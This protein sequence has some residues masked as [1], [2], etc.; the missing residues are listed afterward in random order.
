MSERLGVPKDGDSTSGPCANA[1]ERLISTTGA[2]FDSG[3]VQ[4]VILRLR[5][6]G[7]IG[8][9][10]SNPKIVKI[11]ESLDESANPAHRN[12]RRQGMQGNAWQRNGRKNGA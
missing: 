10:Q 9:P 4:F 12:E 3:V 7:R 11:R 5:I 6:A 2:G 8:H 1:S